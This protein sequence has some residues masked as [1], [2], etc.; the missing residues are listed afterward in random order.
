MKR[1]SN[2]KEEEGEKEISLLSQLDCYCTVL[3]VFSGPAHVI[4]T[5]RQF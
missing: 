2:T 1:M 3:T 4:N 5:L